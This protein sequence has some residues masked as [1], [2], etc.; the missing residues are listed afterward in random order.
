MLRT[1]E[2]FKAEHFKARKLCSEENFL[3]NSNICAGKNIIG[4]ISDVQ[5]V[6]RKEDNKLNSQLKESDFGTE[7]VNIFTA[8]PTD[9]KDLV[10]EEEDEVDKLIDADEELAANI[11]D[12]ERAWL[13]EKLQE[14]HQNG[15]K[16]DDQ[17]GRMLKATADAST[18]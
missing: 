13:K 1:D 17:K 2:I 16:N 10:I 18:H 4:P 6:S 3:D 14:Y 12:Q 5:H 9:F 11:D 7:D 8:R 15:S